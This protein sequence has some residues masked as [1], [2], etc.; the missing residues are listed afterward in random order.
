MTSLN[1]TFGNLGIV[2]RNTTLA[3]SFLGAGT[4][5]SGCVAGT[6]EPCS[7]GACESEPDD[8][9]DAADE[10]ASEAEDVGEAE[11]AVVCDCEC[12]GVHD[13]G[14]IPDTVCPSDVEKVT[15]FM[16]DEDTSNGND[17]DGWIGATVSTGN[18]KLT[19]CRVPGSYF[20]PLNTSEPYAVLRLGSTC[21]AGSEAFARVFDNEDTANDNTYTGNIYPSTSTQS[22]SKTTVAFCLFR[23]NA[24]AMSNFPV[25]GFSYGVLSRQGMSKSQGEG[26]IETDD[27][28]T[29]NASMTTY[30]WSPL[31]FA[32]INDAA[33]IVSTVADS[34]TR[35]RLARVK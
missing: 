8:G 23:G 26:W 3:L 33:Q 15:M 6:G 34:K 1:N 14:V 30:S 21:P 7:D 32:K 35:L 13:V 27:E 24:N 19:F 28:D 22:P 16:D 4:L 9:A 25:L 10:I 31:D 18:T 29:S 17:R 2:L 5:I 11:S 12:D 20:K